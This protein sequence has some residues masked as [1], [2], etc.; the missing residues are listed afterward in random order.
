MF[1][2]VEPV[3]L[4]RHD[5]GRGILARPTRES[6]HPARI[7]KFLPA[8][9]DAAGTQADRYLRCRNCGNAIA[10]NS[11]RIRMQ[12]MHEHRCTNPHGIG[13]RIGCFRAAPGVKETG[14]ETLEY[15]WFPG[16]CW[17]VALC[18]GCNTHLGWG[19]RGQ[20]NDRFCGLIL[21]RLIVP[22]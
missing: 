20:E 10:R 1:L 6:D 5:G 18:G 16:Y 3:A 15:T 21:D 13:F 2:R 4:D 11:D 9:D 17:R 12:G 7:G 19:F 14:A 22:H 8:P